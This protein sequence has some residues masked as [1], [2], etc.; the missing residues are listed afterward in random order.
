[1]HQGE[2]DGQCDGENEIYYAEAFAVGT[3][4][5]EFAAV[6]LPLNYVLSSGRSDVAVKVR[7]TASFELLILRVLL[8][9]R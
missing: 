1:M 2:S 3:A 6:P 9:H 7:A 5:A 8:L 4:L